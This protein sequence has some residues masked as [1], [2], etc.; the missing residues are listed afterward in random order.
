MLM[1]VRTIALAATSLIAL[2]APAHAQ[3][4]PAESDARDEIVV[5][6]QLREQKPIDVPIA[7][8]TLSGDQLDRLGSTN[9][10]RRRASFRASR[11]RTSRPTIPAS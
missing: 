9:S 11:C 6:A 7:V 10:R 3:T 2:V 5:T 1:S 4:A 8:S